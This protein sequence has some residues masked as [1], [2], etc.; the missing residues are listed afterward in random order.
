MMVSQI[1]S[2]NNVTTVKSCRVETDVTPFTL[3]EQRV[4]L[5]TM[6]SIITNHK[7]LLIQSQWNAQDKLDEHANKRGHE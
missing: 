2:V 7:L 6:N 1:M 4:G 3:K 5:F